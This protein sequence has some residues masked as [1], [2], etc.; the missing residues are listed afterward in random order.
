MPWRWRPY[1]RNPWRRRRRWRTF[2]WRPRK[3]FRRRRRFRVRKPKRKLKRLTLHQWQPSSIRLCKIKGLMCLFQCNP[4]R[5]GNNLALYNQSIV[6]PHLPGG[7]G[8]S[9]YQ[10]TL[11]NLYTMHQYVRNWWTNS[12]VNLPLV[13]YVKCIFKIYQSADV[14]I[15]FRY[16]RHFPMEST[17]LTYPSVQPSVMMMLKNTVLIPSKKTRRI[18][19]GY[20]KIVIKPPEIMTNKWYFQQKIATVPLL[21]THC[22]AASFD[23]FYIDSNNLST[24]VTIQ[25]LNTQLIQNRSFGTNAAYPIRV[26]GTQDIWLI[27]SDDVLT[28]ETDQPTYWS[29]TLLADSKNYAE[30]HSYNTAKLLPGAIKPTS[31]KN[32]CEN[33]AKYTGNPF[34][35]H[36]LLYDKTEHTTLFQFQGDYHTIFDKST[37]KTQNQKVPATLALTR[38][39]APLLIPCRYNPNTDNGTTNTTYI[40]PNNK[41]QHG[42]DPPSDKRFELSGFPLYINLWGFLDFQKKQHL[43]D[44]ID[45]NAIVVIQSKALHPLYDTQ[46]KYFVPLAQDFTLG[47][48]PYES[49][50]NPIDEKRWYLMAQYQEPAINVLL[51]CGPGTAKIPPKQS[52]EAKCEYTFI[53]KFGGNPAPMVQLTDPTDQPQYPIPNNIIRTN[54]L[55]DPTTPAELFLYNF[56]ERRQLITK[57]ATERISKD[58]GLTTTLFSDATTVPAAPEILK[59]HQTSEDETS[60]EEEK[61]KTLFQQLLRH[62][63]KQHK[64]K[65]RIKQ[66]LNKMANT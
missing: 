28:T 63:E 8:F 13:R 3:T 7:G 10:Y 46:L 42:W 45:T 43:M 62:R 50:L 49:D 32:Y 59:T 14:D 5:L 47:H 40:L 6:P 15:V 53:L 60:D 22:T 24:N 31:W 25:C 61:E 52:V 27:A 29:L 11:H 9:V 44:K 56:D 58:W 57:A 1:W 39:Q 33:I 19:K 34:H 54:S 48:S 21:I 2:R 26:I 23:N 35:E 55:Q 20:K 64:L 41:G 18:R 37:E 30:G 65:Y 17:N 38:I 12:N 66:I 36:Y 16:F 4:Y 51:S